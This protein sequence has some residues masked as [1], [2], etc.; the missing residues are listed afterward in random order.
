MP[1]T[2]KTTLDVQ[3]TAVTVL[4][5]SVMTT[6]PSRTLPSTKNRIDPTKS[7]RIG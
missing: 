3:G 4:S 2:S 7:S 6:F 5:K 1:K